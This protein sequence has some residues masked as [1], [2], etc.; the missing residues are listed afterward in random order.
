MIKTFDEFIKES[1]E[2]G[3]GLNMTASNASGKK[4]RENSMF[5]RLEDARRF[6]I[7]WLDRNPDSSIEYFDICS[8]SNYS[9]PDCLEVWGGQGGY[10]YNVVNSSYKD[11]QQFTYREMSKIERSEVDI[12]SY[13]GINKT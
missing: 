1:F 8:G 10:F 11:N 5:K 2:S 9:D 12:N 6:M 3:Y 7:D 13:L 4:I